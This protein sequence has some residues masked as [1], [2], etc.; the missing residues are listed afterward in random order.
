MARCPL[1][2]ERPAKRFC[3]A[4]DTS[5]CPVCCGTKREVEIDCPAACSYLQAGRS[6]E[7]ERRT[8]DPDLLARVKPLGDD[9]LYRFSAVMNVLSLGVLEERQRSP[10]LVDVDVIEAYKGLHSTLKTLE[11]GIH[12]ETVPEGAV[13]ASLYH[14]LKKMLDG[15][16]QAQADGTPALKVSEAMQVM[17]FLAFAA[18]VNSNPRP[19]S[20]QYLDWITGM[21]TAAGAAQEQ[22]SSRLIVP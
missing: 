11:G 2:S 18:T 16:M 3:P 22:Q 5:I 13:R 12:Y 9:F 1:C 10:W 8:L 20:R 15:M 14:R 4:K 7:S 21:A 6:Y 17:D 19:K